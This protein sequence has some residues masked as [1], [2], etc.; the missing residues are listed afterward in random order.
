SYSHGA[1]PI[2]V[3]T[4]V[5]MGVN[6]IVASELGIGV[7][8]LLDQKNIRKFKVKAGVPVREAVGL[9]LK[10]LEAQTSLKRT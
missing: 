6:A 4:L 2:A 8:M 10:E 7:S 1:G 5:D 9:I 3:K